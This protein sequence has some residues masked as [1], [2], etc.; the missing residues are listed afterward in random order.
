MG[1]KLENFADLVAGNTGFIKG[2][3]H[4]CTC[5]LFIVYIHLIANLSSPACFTWICGLKL[6][7]IRRPMNFPMVPAR[8]LFP[9]EIACCVWD[10]DLGGQKLHRVPILLVYFINSVWGALKLEAGEYNKYCEW[11]LCGKGGRRQQRVAF[12]ASSLSNGVCCSWFLPSS[13]PPCKSAC[14]V[15]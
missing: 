6:W 12:A 13:E 2:S 14:P 9:C 4:A 15:L 3:Y 1:K 10:E 7:G 5:S 8:G 11:Q